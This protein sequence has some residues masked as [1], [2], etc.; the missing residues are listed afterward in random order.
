MTKHQNSTTTVAGAAN[1]FA[2]LSSAYLYMDLLFC[3]LFSWLFYLYYMNHS[4]MVPFLVII[5]ISYYPLASYI[6]Q[7]HQSERRHDHRWNHLNENLPIFYTCSR[8]FVAACTFVVILVDHTDIEVF[9][10][11]AQV[12]LQ[13]QLLFGVMV[14]LL[15]ALLTVA[16][17]LQRRHFA[18]A[19][20]Q[21]N[22]GFL[23]K[24]TKA[25]KLCFAPPP[26]S[27][28]KNQQRE[29]E[30][31]SNPPSAFL[32]LSYTAKTFAKLQRGRE[33]YSAEILSC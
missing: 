23:V 3:I 11:I 28:L 6:S 15:L 1:L 17:L 33:S 30:G 7:C 31:G 18:I 4:L 32:D 25:D 13:S 12:P 21:E 22:N 24:L 14:V 20:S 5:A 29:R 10:T 2:S 16:V 9:H 19:D 27:Y 26:L 8:F